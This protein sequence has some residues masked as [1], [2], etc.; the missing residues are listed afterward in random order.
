SSPNRR[1]RSSDSGVVLTAFR[2]RPAKWYSMVPIMAVVLPPVRSTES[3][4]YA[5]VVLPL[6]PVMPVRKRRARRGRLHAGDAASVG[7]DGQTFGGG[8]G[9][10]GAHRHATEIGH[11]R[12]LR[13]GWRGRRPGGR[14]ECAWTL[15]NGGRRRHGLRSIDRARRGGVEL[16]TLWARL[17]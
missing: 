1:R 7:E 16:R 8:F 11:A 12:P 9:Q 3:I 15:P 13:F 14:P 5:V 4:R 17:P 10:H 6:V 2:T